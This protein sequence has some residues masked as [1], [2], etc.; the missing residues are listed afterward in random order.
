M[1]CVPGVHPSTL[2]FRPMGWAGGTEGLGIAGGSCNQ[3]YNNEQ[4]GYDDGNCLDLNKNYPGCKAKYDKQLGDGICQNYDRVGSYEVYSNAE[5]PVQ[6][7]G[8]Y[9]TEECEFDGG[10]CVEFN[11]KFPNCIVDE[12]FRV[13]DNICNRGFKNT[14]E[15]GFDSGDCDKFNFQMDLYP[16]CLTTVYNLLDP[17]MF[18]D[19][20]C[21]NDRSNTEECGF[22]DGDC[23]EFNNK[24]PNCKTKPNQD[25]WLEDAEKIGDGV[26]NYG[27]IEA[28]GFD[29]GD[30]VE[31]NKKYPN[32]T[33][34]YPDWVGNGECDEMVN[35][36]DC[37]F[38]GGDCENA[39][40]ND[41]D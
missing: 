24:Y 13:G 35:T 30:C 29:G 17:S 18:G 3:D 14:A 38:D 37:G 20:K 1:N 12:P 28:C 4:C 23:V 16:N 31:F 15:C 11:E 36:A 40:E 6:D 19:G 25:L 26:C 8:T 33:A 21:N 10:D 27:N 22:D 5:I 7:K 2:V 9:N 41:W 34:E 39:N 32:C